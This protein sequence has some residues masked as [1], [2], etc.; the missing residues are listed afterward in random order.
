MPNKILFIS[1]SITSSSTRYRALQ[2]YPYLYQ[3]DFTP[4]HSQ[5]SGGVFTF[6][7]TLYIANK[8][9][10]V[11]VLRKTFPFILTWLL[12]LV[13][14]K[15]IFDLDDAIFCSTDG[16][17]SITRKKRFKNIVMLSDH[18]FA[19]NTF[20]AENTLLFNKSVTV[21]PTCLN[22]KKYDITVNKPDDHIDLVWIGS[23]STSKYLLNILPI[24]EQAA[25]EQPKLRLKIIADF[26]LT[27]AKI[28]TLNIPWAEHTEAEELASSHIGI[29][30]MIENDWTRGKCAL[31]VLQYMAAKLPVIS[32]NVGVNSEVICIGKTGYLV[33]TTNEWLNAIEQLSANLLKQKSM[34]I[35]GQKQVKLHYD[36][37][38]IFKRALP[39]LKP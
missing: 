17:S 27:N 6:L 30:P 15:L 22:V 7:K 38:V 12:K 10:T 11:V 31:K 39:I 8:A 4:T 26:S 25:K 20:L 33:S 21:I 36:N 9:D 19:G 16:S 35:A 2:F 18:V 34:G 14:N 1:K 37:R 29:A 13:S 28:N 23:K 32:S 3:H 5:I 24:L